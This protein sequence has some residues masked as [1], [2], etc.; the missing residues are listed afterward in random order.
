MMPDWPCLRRDW[1]RRLNHPLSLLGHRQPKTTPRTLNRILHPTHPHRPTV[2]AR[3]RHSEILLLLLL[4]CQGNT[5]GAKRGEKVVSSSTAPLSRTTNP[6]SPRAA[7]GQTESTACAALPCRARSPP[8][9]PRQL[10]ADSGREKGRREKRCTSLNM[11]SH[12]L[13]AIIV[14]NNYDNREIVLDI[15]AGIKYLQYIR[16]NQPH[17]D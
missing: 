8:Q 2:P 14:R 10:P 3:S 12:S 16:G 13:S 1:T 6:I 4:G 11:P 7:P 9:L 15:R 17:G 5:S